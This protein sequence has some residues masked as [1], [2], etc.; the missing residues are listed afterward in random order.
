[1][2]NPAISFIV[3]V[4]NCEKYLSQCLQSVLLQSNK[5]FE[6]I[7][8]NDGSTDNSLD[9]ITEFS[10]NNKC[11][12]YISTEN[13]G[14]AIARNIGIGMAKGEYIAFLDSDDVL[15]K[16]ALNSELIEIINKYKPD[17]IAMEYYLGTANL[18]KGDLQSLKAYG[19]VFHDSKEFSSNMYN[20][21]CSY[22]YKSSMIK[23]N[24]IRFPDGIKYAED[25]AFLYHAA[26]IAKNAYL[27]KNPWF[28]YRI[29]GDSVMNKKRGFDF[30]IEGNIKAWWWLKDKGDK[31]FRLSCESLIFLCMA[32]YI[33]LS[34]KRGVPL[35]MIIN[36]VSHCVEFEQV[37]HD[38]DQLYKDKHT[39]EVYQNYCESPIE[40]YRSKRYERFI[41]RIL[42]PL[43]SDK[44][45][46][47]IYL[48]MKYN[49][50]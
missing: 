11:I 38:Y 32:E 27:L 43:R 48:N 15:C 20:L 25:G 28:I 45:I 41:N 36:K 3:P 13:N 16:N 19:S 5:C 31:Q 12:H 26:T 22:I 10:K 34:T 29:H 39:I 37:L 7:I 9:V 23:E 6:I 4:Y 44:C 14:V 49:V 42:D 30:L 8:I 17:L 21:F 1:M 33:E 46:K 50:I 47:Q 35:N 24:N 18:R 2:I 40:F